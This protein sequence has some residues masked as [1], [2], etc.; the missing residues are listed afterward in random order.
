[1]RTT[2]FLAQGLLIV[3]RTERR[4]D[5]FYSPD[6]DFRWRWKS[7]GTNTFFGRNWW[8][9]YCKILDIFVGKRVGTVICIVAACPVCAQW[10]EHADRP[11]ACHRSAAVRLWLGLGHQTNLAAALQDGEANWQDIDEHRCC[12]SGASHTRPRPGRFI[13]S[14][15]VFCCIDTTVA[16][17]W[18]DFCVL[19]VWSR[20]FAFDSRSGYYRWLLLRWLYICRQ[21]TMSVVCI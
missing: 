11:G 20:G 5:C 4:N 13:C 17:W 2:V 21:V 7:W 18:H 19:D 8:T 14:S 16:A 3:P 9:Y 10:L 6:E 1:M 15:V 12:Q